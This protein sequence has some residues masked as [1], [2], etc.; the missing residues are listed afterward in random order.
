M[1]AKALATVLSQKIRDNE[2]MLV[3]SVKFENPKTTE[4]KSVIEGLSKA[5][6]FEQLSTKQKNTAVIGLSELDTNAV[7]SFSNFSNMK[8]EEARNFNPAVLLNYK[9]VVIF[10]AEKS[11]KI[12]SDRLSKTNK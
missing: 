2:L 6:G 8:V 4:A 1:R 11:L 12:L 10:D 5:A 3:D 7:K 9:Y